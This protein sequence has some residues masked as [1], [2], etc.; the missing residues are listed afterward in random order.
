MYKVS[1]NETGERSS[2]RG[3][4]YLQE[5]HSKSLYNER[6]I[7]FELYVDHL[8]VQYLQYMERILDIW[9]GELN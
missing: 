3:V 5:D 1:I 2:D 4:A 6:A 8:Y 7:D 9:I